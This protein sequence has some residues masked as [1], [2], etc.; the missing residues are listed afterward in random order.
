MTEKA[1]KKFVRY[2]DGANLYSMSQ[3]SFETL[4]K[5]AQAV[6][7]INK[8]VLVNTELVDKYLEN[9]RVDL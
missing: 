1:K 5:K 8:M 4:A 9:F 6:Y 2:K 7:K 3:S